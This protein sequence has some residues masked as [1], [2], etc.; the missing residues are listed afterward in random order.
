MLL[1]DYAL[2]LSCDILYLQF[3]AVLHCFTLWGW[4]KGGTLGS[5]GENGILD[6]I[7]MAND[8]ER[9]PDG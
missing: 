5:S 6:L 3:T 4:K 8:D 2:P 9:A 7:N 1:F